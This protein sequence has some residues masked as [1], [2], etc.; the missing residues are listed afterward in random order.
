MNER[1][2]F[3]KVVGA[4]AVAVGTGCG[5]VD[6][7]VVGDGGTGGTGTGGTGTGGTGTTTTTTTTTTTCATPAG[8]AVGK[9]STYAATGLHIVVDKGVLIGRD[10]GG[11]YALTSNLHPPGLRHVHRR[12]PDLPGRTSCASATT[13][14][15]APRA[16]WSPAP[17]TA[18]SRPT[19]SSSAATATST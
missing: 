8:T 4:G 3:L 12:G 1:R 6:N 14:S 11:L 10:S 9:P 15:S 13:A 17:P 16:P 2:R 7:P 19:R 5:G 18:P